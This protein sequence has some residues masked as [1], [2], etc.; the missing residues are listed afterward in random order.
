MADPTMDPSS[1]PSDPTAGAAPDGAGSEQISVTI[2]AV[3]DGS[4]TVSM[5]EGDESEGSGEGSDEDDA[6]DQ[7]Q[8]ASNIDDALKIASEM[9]QAES[10]EDESGDPTGDDD[11]PMTEG[12]AGK[13]WKQMA[14]KKKSMGM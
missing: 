3:G 11:A 1:D 2:T 12:D 5:S 6:S 4:Y 9:F 8:T 14:G 10:S 7:P 13:Y